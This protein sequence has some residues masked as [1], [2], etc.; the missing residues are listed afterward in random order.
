MHSKKQAPSRQL[1]ETRP[2]SKAAEGIR[3]LDPK[4]GKLMLY[5]L[6]YHRVQRPLHA[7]NAGLNQE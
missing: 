2:L 5:Q 4:L 3:T 1:S 6:S 7:G